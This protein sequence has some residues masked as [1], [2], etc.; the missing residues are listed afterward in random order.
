MGKQLRRTLT[1]QSHAGWHPHKERPDPIEILVDSSKGRMK[2]LL[3]IRYGRMLESPFAFFRGAAAIMA[4]DLSR[5]PSTGIYVQACGDCHLANFGGF[6][7]P[8]R[9]II[10]DINDFDE[11]L[12]AP[13]EWDLKRLAASF[14]IASINN[15]FKRQ[16]SRRATLACVQSYRRQMWRLAQTPA[17]EVW[18]TSI[19]APAVMRS[20][21]SPATRK[22]LEKRLTKAR[23]AL[24]TS[25]SR[26]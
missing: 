1:R 8:E 5:T 2:E 25:C 23:E 7:T 18:Y 4:E 15:K 24:P 19:D 13:W 6:A 22:R 16:D 14:V 12:P 21:R 3:P 11:T 20:V 9:R 26:G 10:F 17:L